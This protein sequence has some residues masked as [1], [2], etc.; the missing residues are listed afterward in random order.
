MA[1]N[2][3]KDIAD[4]IIKELDKGNIPWRKE[5]DTTDKSPLPI[6]LAS[7]KGYNGM[8][9]F[10]LYLKSLNS[11]FDDQRF[12][13]FKQIKDKGG[14][15]KKGEKGSPILYYSKTENK[16]NPEKE[17]FFV[18]WSTVF[19]VSQTKGLD[20]GITD[21]KDFKD[22]SWNIEKNVDNILDKLSIT[23]DDTGSDSASYSSKTKIITMPH[24]GAFKNKK[25]YYGT[26]LHEVTHWA[27]DRGVLDKKES[28][29]D[30]KTTYAKEELRAEIGSIMLCAKLGI[31]LPKADENNI[32][33]VKGWSKLLKDQPGEIIKAASDAQKLA[34]YVIEKSGIDISRDNE[35][36]KN[37][38]KKSTPEIRID[39]K[40]E[41]I[42]FLEQ[43]GADLT[44]IEIEDSKKTRVHIHGDK[45]GTQNGEFCYFTNEGHGKP[46]G[47]LNN[48]SSSGEYTK[49][50]SSGKIQSGTS[51][52]P[53]KIKKQ[54]ELLESRKKDLYMAT[55]K[56]IVTE[57]ERLK[58]A[59]KDHPYAVKKQIDIAKSG[60]KIDERKNL[61][62]PLRNEKG[63]ISSCQR[64]W[65][66]GSKQ[67]EKGG[68]LKGSSYTIGKA[69]K[70][71][72][73]FLV[74]GVATGFSVAKLSDYKCQV[75]CA[76][77][78]NNL[79]E[80]AK[81][82]KAKNP[83]KTIIV[84]GDN[85]ELSKQKQQKEGK[86]NPVNI[87]LY[88]AKEAAKEVG[89]IYIIPEFTKNELE[90]GMTDW[91]DYSVNKGIPFAKAVFNANITKIKMLEKKNYPQ[92]LSKN[93]KEISR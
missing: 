1:K 84:A 48:F 37:T 41:F 44:G 27:V 53:E 82:L 35:E 67:L 78:S 16:E 89:G 71:P 8:N 90:Q 15:V 29:E 64:I 34:N 3:A 6:N 33:Y 46:A 65:S 58:D 54:K 70:S 59:P 21:S 10:S 39:P 30:K 18:R 28:G 63:A 2:H 68:K 80:V 47:Y 11:D 25:A 17:K 61:F 43:K 87:G 79:L 57:Y 93:N 72:Y 31:N 42:S 13:T 86:E 74:E 45:K 77:S 92:N 4:S 23:V 9:F 20:L 91:N 62:I 73:I 76:I 38:V 12:A 49:W 19:N 55:S 26:L 7:G 24:K 88:K 40:Q 51:L 56:K 81:N 60:I 5:W 22:P 14:Y 52:S 83:D 69:N 66:N 32:A 85:D 50:T 36:Q 75:E